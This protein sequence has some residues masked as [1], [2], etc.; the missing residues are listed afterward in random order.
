MDLSLAEQFLLIAHH[1]DKQRFVVQGN[2]T[3]LGMMGAML[4]D[5]VENGDI[6]IVEDK[7]IC[8]PQNSGKSIHPEMFT[9]LEKSKKPR[10]VKTWIQRLSYKGN[11][12]K[13]SLFE[14]L[15]AKNYITLERKKFLGF[16]PYNVTGIINKSRHR[17]DVSHYKNILLLNKEA[18]RN[19]HLL[20]SVLLG[21][22]IMPY[23]G[24]DREERK[25]LRKKSKTY[26]QTSII[27]TEV[28]KAIQ[29]MQ[30]AIA[31]SIATT[32][33]T[34]SAIHS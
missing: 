32:A 10:K 15:S 8:T 1:T 33:A 26:K 7:I 27:G 4:L 34:T 21:S 13:L 12:L 25:N 18:S 30:A 2:Q 20:M 23:L 6:E 16:I 5:L 14:N 22:G 17:A 31:V 19:D 28:D 29:H 3:L 24:K 11:K 9:I